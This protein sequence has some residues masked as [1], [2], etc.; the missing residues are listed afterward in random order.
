[1]KI[2]VAISGEARLWDITYDS[3]KNFLKGYDY[4]IYIHTWDTI[5]TPCV[6][7]INKP[8][9]SKDELQAYINRNN[10][11]E[12]TLLEKINKK[13]KPSQIIVEN[14]EDFKK[15]IL[16]RYKCI[17]E[18]RYNQ[19]INS[20]FCAFSQFYSI[21]RSINLIDETKYDIIFRTRFDLLYNPLAIKKVMT[22]STACPNSIF[23]KIFEYKCM[24]AMKPAPRFFM[25]FQFVTGYATTM[26]KWLHDLI[27][28]FTDD[29]DSKSDTALKDRTFIWNMVCHH[30]TL[31]KIAINKGIGIRLLK[32]DSHQKILP[33]ENNEY[34]FNT[35]ADVRSHN[36][37]YSETIG[38]RPKIK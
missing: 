32:V 23:T 18:H 24:S 37:W 30:D 12:Y 19:I 27:E 7:D 8:I 3:L 21:W 28:I 34:N 15:N 6:C 2:A 26:K 38:R 35:L 25:D 22:R 11:N 20:N 16:P 14:R 5:T 10:T 17:P 1:M 29:T 4:D 33:G 13:Y 31:A 9:A 36:K